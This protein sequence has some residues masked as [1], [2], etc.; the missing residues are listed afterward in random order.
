MN[1]L[2]WEGKTLCGDG[3]KVHLVRTHPQKLPRG[4]G[5]DQTATHISAPSLVKRCSSAWLDALASGRSQRLLYKAYFFVSSHRRRLRLHPPQDY[6]RQIASPASAPSLVI[7]RRAMRNGVAGTA[8]V[9]AVA[10]RWQLLPPLDE[11]TKRVPD[12]HG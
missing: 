7:R 8:D 4:H 6:N 1:I 11:Q 12:L 2:W 3:P 9:L 10:A 5:T